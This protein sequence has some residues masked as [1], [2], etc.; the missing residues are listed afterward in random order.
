MSSDCQ[1]KEHGAWGRRT[2]REQYVQIG[3]NLGGALFF[4][5]NANAIGAKHTKYMHGQ[6]PHLSARF[7]LY[8]KYFFS[9]C[10]SPSLNLGVRFLYF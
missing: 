6:S 8:A 1:L 5:S 10:V 2:M 7:S 9:S 4:H 3:S